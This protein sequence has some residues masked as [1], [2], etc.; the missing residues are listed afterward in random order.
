MAV[1]S[2]LPLRHF[3]SVLPGRRAAELGLSRPFVPA[4]TRWGPQ[5]V[6]L[7]R[8][9]AEGA[10]AGRR[11]VAAGLPEKLSVCYQGFQPAPDPE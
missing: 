4:A 6:L 5:A 9:Q 11:R 3:A 7:F 2:V 8:G 10:G 1:G